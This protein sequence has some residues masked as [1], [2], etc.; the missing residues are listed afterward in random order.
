MAQRGKGKLQAHFKSTHEATL[1]IVYG[2]LRLHKCVKVLKILWKDLH[3][4]YN[5]GDL[6]AGAKPEVKVINYHFYR[7]VLLLLL[8]SMR[9]YNISRAQSG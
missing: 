4:I 6:E 9:I 7:D 1:H 3:Q 2:S 5:K 8:I